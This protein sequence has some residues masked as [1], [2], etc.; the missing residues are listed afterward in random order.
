[1]VARTLTVGSTST[2]PKPDGPT[3][4]PAMISRTID[5][6]RSLGA[7]PSRNGA[8][9]PTAT[10][11]SRLVNVGSTAAESPRGRGRYDVGF[12]PALVSAASARQPLP[13]AQAVSP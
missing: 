6:R 5:G 7:S 1:M 12:G 8:E 4:M 2:Q 10:T 9:K 3:T 13:P 11:I